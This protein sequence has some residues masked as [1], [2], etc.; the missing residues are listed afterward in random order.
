MRSNNATW[1]RL[2]IG[3][4]ILLACA[5]AWLQHSYQSKQN[6]QQPGQSN[7]IAIGYVDALDPN[8]HT[9][10]EKCLGAKGIN[11]MWQGSIK[12]EFCVEKNQAAIAKGI[13]K[14]E[15]KVQRGVIDLY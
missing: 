14:L 5:F 8:A 11:V 2:A 4:L 6:I 13:L 7:Y 9:I 10:V 12:H 1:I 15:R 3:C